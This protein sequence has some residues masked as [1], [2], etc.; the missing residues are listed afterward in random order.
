MFN[1][2]T[3]IHKGYDQYMTRVA[4]QHALQ[5]LARQSDATLRDIGISRELLNSGVS[6]WPWQSAEQSPT[7]NAV[8]GAVSVTAASTMQHQK[9]A[10]SSRKTYHKVMSKARA[11]RELRSYSNR[12]LR[13][14][15]ITRD[16]IV[17]AVNHGRP[18]IEQPFTPAAKPA[19]AT[20]AVASVKPISL[21]GKD[22][23]KKSAG[24]T[25]SVQAT[26]DDRQAA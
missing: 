13:D 14:L 17:E 23:D 7:Q 9:L 8:S 10:S 21:H 19:T 11:I 12:E 22:T 6:S 5:V 2:I 1:L 16:S 25:V 18:G 20:T 24:D 3:L 15:G 26:A 4:R